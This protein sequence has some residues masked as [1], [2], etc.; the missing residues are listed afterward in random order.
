MCDGKTFIKPIVLFLVY[1]TNVA[2]EWQALAIRVKYIAFSRYN[3]IIREE[4]NNSGA[5]KMPSE[6]LNVRVR[7]E[8]Q[9]HLQ[10]QIGE[11]GLYEN[12]S[13]YIRALIRS[14]LKSRDE[15]WGW[16]KRHLEPAAR[17]DEGEYISVSAQDV[18]GRNK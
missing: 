1:Q 15:S 18:I 13:E 7:G 2:K 16:L 5:S 8:L 4:R 6:N 10:Q 17:A 3:V 9:A 12:A 14:D 11:G